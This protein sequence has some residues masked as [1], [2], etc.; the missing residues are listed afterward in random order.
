MVCLDID[1]TFVA[2]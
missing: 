2:N 1:A